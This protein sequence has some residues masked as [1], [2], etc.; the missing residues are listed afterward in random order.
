MLESEAKHN[1]NTTRS[2]R[3]W[4]AIGL[5]SLGLLLFAIFYIYSV[6]QQERKIASSAVLV[7]EFRPRDPRSLVQG[8]YMNMQLALEREISVRDSCIRH[9][10]YNP[11]GVAKNR[12]GFARLKQREPEAGE[13]EDVFVL[14]EF[15]ER[16]PPRQNARAPVI[17]YRSRNCLITIG[18]GN[19]FFQEGSGGRFQAAQFVRVR[20]ADDGSVY[21]EELLDENM[22]RIEARELEDPEAE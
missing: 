16:L 15:V 20:L 13:T 1:R 7:L 14:D 12:T 5:Y 22:R 19:F 11:S 17:A 21:A 10:N 8:D 18:S 3:R 4:F 2:G 9:G 6:V